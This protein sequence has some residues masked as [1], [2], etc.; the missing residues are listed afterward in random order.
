MQPAP[1]RW[2]GITSATVRKHHNFSTQTPQQPNHPTNSPSLGLSVTL[3]NWWSVGHGPTP[4]PLWT[5]AEKTEKVVLPRAQRPTLRQQKQPKDAGASKDRKHII[6]TQY[7]VAN[8]SMAAVAQQRMQNY[9]K[10]TSG[11]SHKPWPTSANLGSET[12]DRTLGI[13]HKLK[14]LCPQFWFVYP[15]RSPKDLG[16]HLCLVQNVCP[17]NR[18]SPGR[19]QACAVGER[20]AKM[21]Q[22][23]TIW[24][25]H[26][27]CSMT[28]PGTYVT[29]C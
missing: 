7:N 1:T 15:S 25:I 27:G 19:W 17:A 4:L 8:D 11:L 10:P 9:T 2:R 23:P 24:V 13:W 21:R 3:Q 6:P 26:C 18:V 28:Q 29:I 14:C 22:A 12:T 16:I 20:A 5:W